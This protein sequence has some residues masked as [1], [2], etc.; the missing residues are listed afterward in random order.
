MQPMY[1]S[2]LMRLLHAL[3]GLVEV[4]IVE[5]DIAS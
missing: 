3:K 1:C 2:R 4:D 5:V